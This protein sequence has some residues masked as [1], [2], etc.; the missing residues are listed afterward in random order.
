MSG[1]VT[2]DTHADLGGTTGHG[3]IEYEPEGVVFHHEWEAKT[4][5]LLST[6]ANGTF[7]ATVVPLDDELAPMVSASCREALGVTSGDRVSVT[8]LP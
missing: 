6:E 3:P 5:A 2:H 7:R 8:P 1:Y 4:L